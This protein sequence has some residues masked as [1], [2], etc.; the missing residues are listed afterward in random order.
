MPM[1][2]GLSLAGQSKSRFDRIGLNGTCSKLLPE[3]IDCRKKRR[4]WLSLCQRRR[5]D[6]PVRVFLA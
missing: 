4:P 5:L 6:P 3:S 1:A 2:V